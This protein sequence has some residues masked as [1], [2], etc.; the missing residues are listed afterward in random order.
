MK[1][2]TLFFL[3]LS[4]FALSEGANS[5][6]GVDDLTSKRSI[7]IAASRI[8]VCSLFLKMTALQE[9]VQIL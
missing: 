6:E 5:T 3:I 1:Y 4:Q 8:Q 7:Y 9:E 2:L